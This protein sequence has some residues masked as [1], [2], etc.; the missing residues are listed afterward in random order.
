MPP[1]AEWL[2]YQKMANIISESLQNQLKMISIR[3]RMALTIAC[4]EQ[5][6]MDN[7][8]SVDG[9]QSLLNIFWQ[10]VETD[11]LA[12]WDVDRRDHSLLIDICDW[13]GGYRSTKPDDFGFDQVED[14]VYELIYEIYKLGGGELYGAV[15]DYSKATYESLVNVLTIFRQK[16]YEIPALDAYLRL[17]FEQKDK[18][19]AKGWGAAVPRTFF[20]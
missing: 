6:L 7:T 8:V 2:N 1:L 5:V 14:W 17:P 19:G 4:L 11:D 10:F 9:R 12:K 20:S 15:C 13:V 16:G 18:W 3:G